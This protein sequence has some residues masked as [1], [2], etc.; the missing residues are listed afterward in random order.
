MVLEAV[1]IIIDERLRRCRR[2]RLAGDLLRSRPPA[3]RGILLLP[4]LHHQRFNGDFY[5]HKCSYRTFTSA[6][7]DGENQHEDDS[8][9]E[10]EDEEEE[11][12]HDNNDANSNPFSGDDDD[13]DDP[14]VEEQY[15]RKTPLEHVLL[16]PGMYVGPNERLPPQ[17]CWV[18]ENAPPAPTAEMLEQLED[19]SS[20]SSSPASE[21]LSRCEW[22]KRSTGW[23]LRS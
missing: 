5:A 18:L 1:I 6:I 13:D 23:Y 14:S 21:N 15:S 19:P 8:E 20:S 3:G 2:R 22:C 9:E 11:E 10:T 12:P 17:S 4:I 16:R 7:P